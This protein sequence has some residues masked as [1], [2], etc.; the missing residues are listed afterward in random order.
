MGVNKNVFASSS[1]RRNYYKLSRTWGDKFRIY[2]NLP[3]LNLF[4][5]NNLIDFS[6]VSLK[7]ID[8]DELDKNRLKKTSI[9]YTLCNEQD[10]PLV[11]IDFDGMCEGFNVGTKYYADYRPDAWREK[12]TELKLTVTHG[13]FFPYFVVCSKHF[14]DVSKNIQLTIIDGIIGDILSCQATHKRISQGFIPEEVGWTLEEFENLHPSSQHEIVQDWVTDVEVESDIENNPIHQKVIQLMGEVGWPSHRTEF[15][16][17]PSIDGLDDDAERARRLKSALYE[18]S[19]YT[20]VTSEYGEIT[21]E[22]LLPNFNTPYFRGLGLSE[23]IAEL[24][25]LNKF[26]RLMKAKTGR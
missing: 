24:L 26:R 15:I 16:T 8:V 22:V 12:I 17:H 5:L 10:E 1:E 13:S 2:H 7:S 23:A 3:F 19:R 20:L 9:D 25:A 4:N 14:E 11:C 18:G 21:T 6:G